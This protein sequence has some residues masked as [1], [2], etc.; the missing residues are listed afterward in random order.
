MRSSMK[1]SG[2]PPSATAPSASS[3][4]HG[5]PI[6][7]TSTMSSGASSRRAISLPIATPPRGNASTTG[8][9]SL[10]W[11]SSAARRSPASLRSRNIGMP[12]PRHRHC[13][14]NS[15]HGTIDRHACITKRQIGL[16]LIEHH[17][18]DETVIKP[19]AGRLHY[20]WIVA[21]VTF[22]VVLLTAG[23]RS[24][25]SVLIVPLEEEFH[26]SRATISFAVGVNLLLYGLVGP[27]AA[28]LM[29]RFGVR[30]T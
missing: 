6:L 2:V 15:S 18:A 26:W 20:A 9:L 12:H 29:D 4:C 1:I 24:A 19:S 3:F 23:V 25:P 28:A 8:D 30:R 11:R 5:T 13:K 16:Q 14:P 21:A 22:V 10:R 17:V 27:F 7:R